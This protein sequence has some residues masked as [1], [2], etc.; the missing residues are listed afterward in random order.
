MKRIIFSALVLFIC[1]PMEVYA[2]SIG[3]AENQGKGK[4]GIGADESI[5]FNKDLKFKSASGLGATQTIKNPEIDNAS[6]TMLKASYG[7]LDNLDIYIK[8]GTADYEVKAD[9]YAGSSKDADEKIN[10]D[11]SFAYGLGL[12]GTWELGSDWLLGYDLQYLRSKHEADVTDT[13]VG[14][15]SSSTKYKSAVVQEW[16]VAPYIAKKI[17]DFTPYFGV[18]YSD[19]RLDM[20]NPSASGWTDNHKYEADDNVGIFAG[21][22]YKIGENW[23]VNLEGRFIDETAMSFGATYKF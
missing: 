17:N 11:T 14:G 8:L 15:V 13:E 4:L 18:R 21:T 5:V 9:S 10:S 6:Q 1:L 23:K 19:M 12:K 2:A 3:G 16:H 22:D 7:L 20:K